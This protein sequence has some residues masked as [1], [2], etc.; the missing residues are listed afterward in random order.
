MSSSDAPATVIAADLTWTG[1]RFESGVRVRVRDGRI[2]AVGDLAESPTLSLPG[3]ALMP[4]FV[5]AHSHAFQRGLRGLGERF[6]E[7]AGSFWTWREA[8]YGLVERATPE[9]V[10]AVSRAAFEEMLDAGITTV[11]EFHY[12]HHAAPAGRDWSLDAAVRRA[13][14][15]AGI[16]L[17]LIEVAY[18]HGGTDEPLA[19]GQ[20]RFDGGSVAEVVGRLD[21][22]AAD[23]DPAREHLAASAHS[24]RAV[25]PEELAEL[26]AAVRDR[27]LPLHLHLEEQPA[28]I[29]AC[30]ARHGV[31]P[32]ALVC[33]TIAVDGSVVAVHATHTRPEDF[34]RWGAAGGGVCLCPLTEA[35]LGD[36]LADGPAMSAAGIEPSLGTDSNARI[37]MLEEMRWMEL[38][39]RLRSGR[40]GVFRDAGGTVAPRLLRAATERGAAALGIP[41]GAIRPGM[42]ADLMTID[43]N[44]PAIAGIPAGELDAA[45][46]F[47]AGDEVIEA[48][49]VGG[50]WRPRRDHRAPTDAAD[51]AAASIAPMTGSP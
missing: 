3:R 38:G 50:R 33:D 7:N 21:A 12:L 27:G 51:A 49:A 37:S 1:Q 14:A 20:R 23:L 34:Q 19:G 13:A 22:L 5:N 29:E 28:E 18:L 17:V 32:I 36:G 48:T 8:M 40:R 30:R 41:A 26:H 46:I 10:E 25:T 43:L 45:L 9:L 4:G 6:P 2:E 39:Q 24:V 35:N 44:H 31:G 47:G 15:A 42:L 16:R 11:G